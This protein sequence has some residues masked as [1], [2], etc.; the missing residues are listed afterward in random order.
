MDRFLT[1]GLKI[2]NQTYNYLINSRLFDLKRDGR[3]NFE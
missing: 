2:F 3:T 1:T